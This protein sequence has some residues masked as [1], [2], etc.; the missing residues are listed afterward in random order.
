MCIHLEFD[1][2]KATQAL[3]FFAHKSG[4][5]INKLKAIK[6]VYFADRYHLRKFGRPITNDEYF[7]MS[8]GP[9]NSGVK[10]IAEMSGFL[11]DKEAEYARKYLRIAN[12]YDFESI[13][14]IDESVFSESDLE[15]LAFA[16]GK[17]GNCDR[18]K[19]ADMSHGYPEWKRHEQALKSRSRVRMSYE[20]FLDDPPP[21]FDKC[22]SLSEE[23]KQSLLEHLEELKRIEALWG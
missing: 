17:F 11:G 20:D 12:S 2:Q 21:G 14:H 15:A 4:G 5:R 6:L 18:F 19:L 10:D 23:D 16:W 9:V 1:H 8:Y 7:A 3:N 13:T 22:H